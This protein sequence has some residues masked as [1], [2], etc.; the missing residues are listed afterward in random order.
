MWHLLS[1]ESPLLQ[2]QSFRLKM[3]LKHAANKVEGILNFKWLFNQLE[4]SFFN[5]FQVE[6]VL[7]E[8]FHQTE[9]TLHELGVFVGTLKT[10]G[11]G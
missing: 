5:H 1:S 10:V 8:A 4:H 7:N 9:L 6:E 11:I 2:Y 3:R